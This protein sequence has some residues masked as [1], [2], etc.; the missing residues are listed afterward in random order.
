M[1][2]AFAGVQWRELFAGCSCCVAA[3]S[4]VLRATIAQLMACR[5]RRASCWCS[6]DAEPAARLLPLLG[7]YFGKFAP[8]HAVIACTDFSTHAALY[9]RD[10][11]EED[12]DGNDVAVMGSGRGNQGAESVNAAKK[13]EGE[14]G[15]RGG[16]S[17]ALVT[18]RC[19]H[20]ASN[21]SWRISSCG[22]T[23]AGVALGSACLV[24]LHP[25]APA[26]AE[27]GSSLDSTST[28]T[29]SSSSSSSCRVSRRSATALSFAGIP[30]RGVVCP[31]WHSRS[32]RPPVVAT[33]TAT[34]ATI[35]NRKDE[36]GTCR[37]GRALARD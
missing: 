3:A 35:A 20:I 27:D 7:K 36:C 18:C 12:D 15:D 31:G 9:H 24:H 16:S 13:V 32:L 34:S 17:V 6:Q 21:S 23:R 5:G 19:W 22:W 29:P 1:A 8:L 4:P 28:S 25:A 14:A 2:P 30:K 10:E 26:T 33:A 11:E 37:R